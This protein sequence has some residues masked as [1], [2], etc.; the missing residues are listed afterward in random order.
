V[1]LATVPQ[2][3]F[4]HG[5]ADALRM[6]A[7]AVFRRAGAHPVSR[8]EVGDIESALGLVAARFGA[9]VVSDHV[10]RIHR[11]PG[12]AFVPIAT[13][14]RVDLAV[15]WK[16]QPENSVQRKFLELMGVSSDAIPVLNAGL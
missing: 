2:I 4:A 10:A 13:E 3:R 9:C 5:F 14:L 15:V 6:A 7:T 16:S 8:D 11:W 1:Q 12:V